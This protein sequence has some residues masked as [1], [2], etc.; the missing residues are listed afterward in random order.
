ML[1]LI[2]AAIGT[3]VLAQAEQFNVE[4]RA[5]EPADIASSAHQYRADRQTDRNAPEAWLALMRYADQ[6][7]TK[8]VDVN[9]SAIKRAV[10]AR[11]WE[12]IRPVRTL[13]LIWSAD[14][15][16]RPAPEDVKVTTLNNQ[17]T[18]RSWWNNQTAVEQAV[19]QTVS[20][21]VTTYI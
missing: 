7:L 17:G 4:K 2:T 14:A 18:A 11:L 3:R 6:P 12:E 13:D 15:R 10:G 21:N 8:P 20:G 19:K 9:A 1:V 5:G 16:R